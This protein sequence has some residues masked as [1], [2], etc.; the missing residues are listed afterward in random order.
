MTVILGFS[1]VVLIDMNENVCLIV[2]SLCDYRLMIGVSNNTSQR[3]MYAI[4]STLHMFLNIY[5]ISVA[6]R[7][8]QI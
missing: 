8:P 3:K 2:V 7:T 4:F 5:F 6:S 1:E